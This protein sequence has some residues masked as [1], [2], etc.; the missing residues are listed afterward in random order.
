[1]FC[2]Q[3]RPGECA[4]SNRHSVSQDRRLELLSLH[5]S[6]GCLRF[7]PLVEICRVV[8]IQSL[9]AMFTGGRDHGFE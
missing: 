5:V 4:W 3:E 1:M 6:F 2:T 7:A 9:Q 8:V